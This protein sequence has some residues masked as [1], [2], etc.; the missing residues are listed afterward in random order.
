MKSSSGS[1]A[2]SRTSSAGASASCTDSGESIWTGSSSNGRS[3]GIGGGGAARA[4][5]RCSTRAS[6]RARRSGRTPP[7]PNPDRT[8]LPVARPGP[9]ANPPRTA[10]LHLNSRFAA[11]SFEIAPEAG[12]N[13]RTPVIPTEFSSRKPAF[14]GNQ[15]V[16]AADSKQ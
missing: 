4:C 3:D 1:T 5:S 2:Y 7:P 16:V 11:G 13:G 15:H 6:R 10:A 8:P 9:G 14:D 12:R